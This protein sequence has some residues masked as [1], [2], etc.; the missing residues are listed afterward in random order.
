M[1]APTSAIF[2]EIYLQYIEHT[3]LAEILNNHKIYGYFRYVDDILIIYNITSTDIN[4]VL[5][6]FN[7]TTKHLNFT[8]ENEVNEQLSYLDITISRQ[9]NHFDYN[10]YR[11]PTITNHMIPNDSCHPQEHKNA[12]HYLINRIN[13][14]PLDA[15]NRAKENNH[16][17]DSTC[18]QVQPYQHHET[19]YTES[20]T[21]HSDKYPN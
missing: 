6:Q 20:K 21:K 4:T 14:Y 12:I 10:I 19:A 17:T 13:T 15:I 7:S 11:K 8:I 3:A 9:H 5:Q 16:S 18:Q 1:G 2:S